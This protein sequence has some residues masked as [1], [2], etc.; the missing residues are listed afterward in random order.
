MIKHFVAGVALASMSAL[1][2]ADVTIAVNGPFS[3]QLASFGEQFKRG[4]AMVEKDLNAKGGINGQKVVVSYGDDQCDPK[5][6]VNVANKAV[7]DKVTAVIG[8]FCS[9]SSIPASDVYKEEGIIQISP[10]STNPKFT[11]RGLKNVFRV[12]GRDDQQGTVAGEFIAKNFKGKKVA[13]LHDKTAYGQGLAEETQKG[14]AKAGGKEVLFEAITPGE[15]DYS[16]VVSKL[17]ANNVDLVYLGGYHPEAGLI[18]KQLREQ[19]S[20]AVLMSGDAQNDKEFWK[21]AGNAGEGTL[22]T[23][24][25]DPRKDPKNKE[26]IARFK[27][28]NYD[29]EGYTLYTYASFQ[30]YAQAATIAKSFKSADVEKAIRANTFDTVLGKLSFDAK[31]DPKLPGYVVYVWSKG[32]YDYLK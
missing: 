15:K 32:D 26:L 9:G 25:P 24:S 1:A 12:C 11:D 20:K 14:L 23:F 5:Q 13:I 3:G 29:P 31:G 28:E 8:H 19:G 21:I 4:A 10:A 18:V 22:F 2:L 17:K 16:A 27:A 30:V 7:N 6:A